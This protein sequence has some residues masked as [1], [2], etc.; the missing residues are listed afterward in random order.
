MGTNLIPDSERTIMESA[1]S[2]Q[3]ST[4]MRALRIWSDA[5]S[6]TI[7]TSPTYSMFGDHSQNSAI[8][9]D[10]T[11][12]TPQ[13]AIISGC[14]LYGDKQPWNFMGLEQ[15]QLKLRGAEGDI[16][17]KVQADGYALLNN[18]KLVTLDGF[19]FQSSSTPRPHGLIGSPTR[20]TFTYSRV[21]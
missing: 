9:E 1:L 18:A 4:F 17:I 5:Q 3:F 2:D 20:W 14:I 7:S 16:R 10:N 13:F 19:S 8:T 6:V 11:A 21:E 12:V 15:G